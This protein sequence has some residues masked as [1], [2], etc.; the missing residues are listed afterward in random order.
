MWTASLPTTSY[1]SVAYAPYVRLEAT[2]DTVSR[3][4][5]TTDASAAGEPEAW[6]G[7][8]F[9]SAGP[10]PDSYMVLTMGK[11]VGKG[12]KFVTATDEAQTFSKTG[13]VSVNVRIRAG[14][15]T[16]T[17]PY[18]SQIAPFPIPSV[19]AAGQPVP[20]GLLA[21]TDSDGYLE[22][23]FTINGADVDAMIADPTMCPRKTCELDD[24][25]TYYNKSAW[26]P[27]TEES[28]D[29]LGAVNEHSTVDAS[30]LSKFGM[31]NLCS[32][33]NSGAVGMI[34]LLPVGMQR[35]VPWDTLRFHTYDSGTDL[36]DWLILDLIAPYYSSPISFRNSTAGKINLNSR[37]Y[38]DDSAVFS[39]PKRIK[40]LQALLANMPNGAEAATALSDWQSSTNAFDY[41]GR[42]TEVPGVADESYGDLD[43]DKEVILRNLA[44]MMTTQSNVFGVWGAAQTIKKSPKSQA[45]GTFEEGD[46]IV[47]EKRFYAVV[48]RYVWSGRD[49][50]PGNG[51]VDA[52]A[53]YSKL[54]KS[55]K[56]TTT[57][58]GMPPTD[59]LTSKGIFSGRVKTSDPLFQWPP[60]DGPHAPKLDPLHGTADYTATSAESANNPLAAFMKYRIIY[61][62]YID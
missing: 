5:T 15:G 13:I 29:S 49:G 9:G 37:I 59:G 26:F 4:N 21:A 58:P 33:G 35:G 53:A 42:I 45:Y 61:F 23:D 34:S 3:V 57:S 20:D 51:A 43:F 24:P 1:Q 39:P 18:A 50:T 11:L 22:F 27:M 62:T 28:T 31:W 32:T 8:C 48:E 54:A 16:S 47:G 38:P 30:K 19:E 55:K 44:G 7:R 14:I 46:M 12:G 2:S 36:P 10:T 56:D 52:D 40:P 17:G 25:R 41:V 60:I 6:K